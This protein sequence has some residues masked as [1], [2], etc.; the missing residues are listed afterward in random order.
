MHLSS[1]AGVPKL[2]TMASSPFPAG[3]PSS[4]PSDDE[5]LVALSPDLLAVVGYD[6]VVRRRNAAWTTVLPWMAAGF[7][8][9]VFRQHLHP[10]DRL[11]FESAQRTMYS[12]GSVSGVLLRVHDGGRRITFEP[13]DGFIDLPGGMTKFTIRRDPRTGLYL[14]LSNPNTAPERGAYQRNILALCASVDVRNWRVCRRG[15]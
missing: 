10:D 2:G 4:T 3:T 5:R 8:P 1:A 15:G 9:E 14:T 6:G 13:G 7:D 11:A 12:G